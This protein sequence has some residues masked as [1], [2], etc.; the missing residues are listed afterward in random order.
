MRPALVAMMAQAQI[1]DR[2]EQAERFRRAR[3]ARAAAPD[4]DGYE[5]VTV[6]R[7][8]P[9]DGPALQ[10]LAQ[11]DGRRM[12]RGAKLVAEVR[13][14]LLAARSLEDGTSISDPFHPT[15]HLVELLALRSAHLRDAPG[16]AR[17]GLRSL[18]HRPQRRAPA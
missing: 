12:P 18:I 15:A 1:D 14:V 16:P 4:V 10:Q 6:R 9:D 17:R 11:R 5:S 3:R 7:S 8:Y 13:G 2:L